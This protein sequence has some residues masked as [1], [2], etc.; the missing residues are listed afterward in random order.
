[1]GSTASAITGIGLL[2]ELAIS[3]FYIAVYWILYSKA[4]RPGWGAVIPFYNLYLL[5]K[6]VGRSGWWL[7]LFL[8]PFVNIIAYIIVMLDLAKVFGRGSGFAVG[9]ILLPWLFLPILALGASRYVGPAMA[10]RLGTA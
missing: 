2:A 10:P 5:C 7:V 1:V 8:I 3:V 6:I 9:L 4:G